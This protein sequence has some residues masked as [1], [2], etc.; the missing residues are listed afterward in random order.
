MTQD[1]VVGVDGV[2]LAATLAVPEIAHGLVIFAHGGGSPRYCEPDQ[3]VAR[4]LQQAGFATLLVDVLTRVEERRDDRT[5]TF[6]FDRR[7]LAHRL[8][9]VTDWAHLHPQ[10]RHLPIGYFVSGTG[11]AAAI[12]SAA[13]RAGLVETIVAYDPRMGY[14]PRLD[15]MSSATLRVLGTADHD[16]ARLATAWFVH[17]LPHHAEAA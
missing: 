11:A 15:E 1:I 7:L 5:A 2:K 10:L 13:E 12:A 17:H 9:A 16:V 8:G 3:S 6:R 14:L 4:A